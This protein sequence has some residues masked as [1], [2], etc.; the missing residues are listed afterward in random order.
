MVLVLASAARAH[1]HPFEMGIS[2]EPT[3]V[4]MPAVAD[5]GSIPTLAFAAGGALSFEFAPTKYLSLIS[6][7]A[8]THPVGESQI[9]QAT[10][11]NRTGNYFF[12]QASAFVLGG[13][14]LETP[15]WWL[16]LQFTLSGS[17]GVALLI[18]DK[19][20][21]RNSESVTYEISLPANVRPAPLVALASGVQMRVSEH[22]RLNAEGT[23][24]LLPVKQLLVG[25][26]V[27]LGITFLFF[28]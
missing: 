21:L 3:F 7:L 25:F 12:S 6:R 16:P 23:A 19:R 11:A 1:A 14:R 17:A 5:E 13:L 10:F 28:V 22:V 18:Q 2:I 8:Y 24:Y 20:E 9:G 27:N 26:G 15:S 4:G